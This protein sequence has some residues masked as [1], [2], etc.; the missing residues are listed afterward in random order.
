M[1]G[2]KTESE[3]NEFDQR[4]AELERE[5][6]AIAAI[7][8]RAGQLDAAAQAAVAAQGRAH[9]TLAGIIGDPMTYATTPAAELEAAKQALMARAKA[10]TQAA[11]ELAAHNEKYADLPARQQALHDATHKLAVEKAQVG[12]EADMTEFAKALFQAA[13]CERKVHQDLQDAPAGASLIPVT[14]PAGI[15]RPMKSP[16]GRDL[17]VYRDSC[18]KSI[19]MAYPEVLLKAL[20]DEDLV[21]ELLAEVEAWR[22]SGSG[23]LL[24]AGQ[25]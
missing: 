7:N 8:A 5:G 21:S 22:A 14:A 16:D 10:A 1:F 23:V 19:A 17:S 3:A 6:V 13:E 4:A 15:F 12:Y 2:R 11:A 25:P 20:P 9:A 18:L 24:L